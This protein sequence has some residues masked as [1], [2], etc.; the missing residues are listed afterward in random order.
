[1]PPLP[2]SFLS[3]MQQLLGD[4]YAAFLASYD[5]PPDVGLR[6]N[7][8]KLSRREFQTISPFDLKPIPWSE[9]GFV[10]PPEARPGKHPYHAAGLYYLQD[11]SA[12]AVAELLSPQPGERVLDIAAAPG[13][14]STH[15]SALMGG[16]GLLVANDLHPRRAQVLAKNLERWGARNAVVLNET[17]ARLA[18]HFGACF[19]RVV[20]DAPCSGEGMFRKDPEARA[21]WMPKLVKSCAL[22][23]DVLLEDAATLVRP[24]GVLVYA[25]CTFA[26]E[27]DEGAIARFLLAHPRFEL[28][29][30]PR[31]PGFSPGRPD[32]IAEPG[33][34]DLR[35]A[36]R[37]WP[38]KA[39]G[40][41][42][43][44]AL[45]RRSRASSEMPEAPAPLLPIPLEPE[46]RQYFQQYCTD[47]LNWRPPESRLSQM[48]F[49]LYQIPEA[50]PDL[51]GLKVILWGWWLGALKKNRFE[52]SHALGMGLRAEDVRNTLPLTLD[53]PEVDSYLRGE[54]LSSS[55]AD[56][57]V[58]V[59]VDG[60][61]LG[62]GKRVQGR[63][64]THLPRWL[65]QF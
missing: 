54:V 3:R 31:F 13:G 5:Q 43:F 47:A 28:V 57:W 22:R 21:E 48:G 9:A 18:D 1:M 33:R 7:T 16:E 44:I 34:A 41:G 40:E 64:K 39:P 11:P 58:L 29:E 2:P 56:G 63:L 55:G 32:W 15:I 46:P 4:E 51:R 50:C 59:T 26:P 42:H 49:H 24:G 65:R 10:V 14:K 60:H 52:P 37:L 35:R 17:P 25:T 45:L 20:V 8:S 27:E 6:V 30:P 19:D 23:Q 53:D 36:V 12:M 62:W 61:P 38:H